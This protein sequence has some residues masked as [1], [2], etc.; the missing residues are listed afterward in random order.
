MAT[1][2]LAG[3]WMMSMA[4]AGGFAASAQTPT[5]AAL[6]AFDSWVEAE[7]A[8]A[9]GGLLANISP[10]GT[11]AGAVVAS[12]SRR[13]PDYFFHWTRDAA[14]VMDVVAGW[15]SSTTDAAARQEY[16]QLLDDYVRFSR[17]TQTTGTPSGDSSNNYAGY[18][19]PK[20]LVNGQAFVDPWGRPQN[21][22]PA[23]RAITLVRYIKAARAQGN[24]ALLPQ[25]YNSDAR[26]SVLK[27]DLEFVYH[28]WQDTGFDLWEEVRG[29]HFYTALVQRRALLAGADIAE[30]A[31]DP[32]AAGAYREKAQAIER[33]LSRFWD[34]RRGLLLTRRRRRLQGEQY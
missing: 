15:Y 17:G 23:L 29:R 25:L 31:D 30:L 26:R 4:C 19:E 16:A 32:G 11:K 5:T 34:D 21:D 14:L 33:S 13:E 1:K 28:H 9:K 6:P 7:A 8:H 24:N 20:F 10:A 18:G 2:M 22:G 27:S 12:P 3:I